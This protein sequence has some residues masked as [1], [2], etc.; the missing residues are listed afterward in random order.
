MKKYFNF[1]TFIAI[2][3]LIFGCEEDSEPNPLPTS[4]SY[5]DGILIVN[6]GP[7]SNGA[8]TISYTKS[9][10]SVLQQNIFQEA[11]NGLPLGSIAQ[12]MAVIGEKAYIL[13]NNSNTIEVVNHNTFK[14]V[15]TIQNIELP[16]YMI[17][18]TVT[19]SYVT[20]WDGKIKVINT[21]KDEVY[22]EIIGSASQE[23]LLKVDGTVWVLNQGGYGVDS[24]IS[25]ININTDNIDQ[26][27]DVFPRP[28]GICEDKDGLVWIMCSGRS[29]YHEGGASVGHLVAINKFDYAI[30]KDFIFPD[31]AK[32]AQSLVIN[33]TG[34]VLYYIYPGGINRFHIYDNALT[35]DPFIS[36]SSSF[37]SIGYD[38]K[39][40]QIYASD[41]LDY[42]QKGQVIVYDANTGSEHRSFKAGIV[43]TYFYFPE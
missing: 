37:Y 38:S 23:K 33:E 35:L 41:V 16:R 39:K 30:E 14:S 27:I 28:T 29:S 24:T 19:K 20:C 22:S 15:A 34:D 32:Q 40:K 36:Y 3:F 1:I 11:N 2:I 17:Q 25:V 13:M 10:G 7:F 6:E 18:V 12:S 31:K 43:P 9:D 8:G 4:I 5:S 42:V 21:I 26:T